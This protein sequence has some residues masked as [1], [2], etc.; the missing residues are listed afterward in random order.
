MVNPVSR[1]KNSVAP[2]QAAP[3]E[4]ILEIPELAL[5]ILE[6]SDFR[7]FAALRRVNHFLYTVF[8]YPEL[9][10][11]AWACFKRHFPS[12]HQCA[13]IDPWSYGSQ[14]AQAGE[15]A[16]KK[17]FTL[18]S[19]VTPRS[20]SS[21]HPIGDKL[22]LFKEA[23]SFLSENLWGGLRCWS[24]QRGEEIRSIPCASKAMKCFIKDG[25]RLIET[26]EN[27]LIISDIE[28]TT[29]IASFNVPI[30]SFHLIEGYPLVAISDFHRSTC[31]VWNYNTQESVAVSPQEMYTK[32]CVTSVGSAFYV[33]AKFSSNEDISNEEVKEAVYKW[34]AKT[35]QWDDPEELQFDAARDALH[36]CAFHKGH[37][38]FGSNNSAYLC[39]SEDFKVDCSKWEGGNESRKVLNPLPFGNFI[40]WQLSKGISTLNTH[41]GITDMRTSE[42]S[43]LFKIDDNVNITAVALQDDHL[44][45]ATTKTQV[46]PLDDI[47]GAGLDFGETRKDEVHILDFGFPIADFQVVVEKSDWKG[48]RALFDALSSERKNLLNRCVP[49]TTFQELIQGAEDNQETSVQILHTIAQQLP[50]KFGVEN[51]QALDVP[52]DYSSFHF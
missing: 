19:F 16:R 51:A 39:S 6:F 21:L 48:L 15:S 44:F 30:G 7:D 37:F 46:Y 29:E 17:S 26:K 13:S 9:D 3:V 52:Y 38:F 11:A 34:D 45:I 36:S 47:P 12:S 50:G 5:T 31:E 24:W 10:T 49:D 40:F 28:G 20:V 25:V 14:Q 1:A 27:D 35:F 4:V 43:I 23:Q 8:N 18:R 33:T 41:I 42:S 2:Y 32:R 22:F